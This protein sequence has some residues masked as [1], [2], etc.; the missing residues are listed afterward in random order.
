MHKIRPSDLPTSTCP[1]K[2]FLSRFFFFFS[3]SGLSA[4]EAMEGALELDGE[5]IAT[6][7]TGLKFESYD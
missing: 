4:V 1:Q 5:D 6:G 3:F 2:I 7:F